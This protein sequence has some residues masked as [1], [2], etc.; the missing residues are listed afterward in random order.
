MYLMSFSIR[1]T[2]LS[3][4]FVLTFPPRLVKTISSPNDSAILV[5]DSPRAT[6]LNIPVTI[7]ASNG[8]ISKLR[9]PC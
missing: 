3:F 2:N 6:R 7:S 5:G 1:R 9:S 8:A 4:L